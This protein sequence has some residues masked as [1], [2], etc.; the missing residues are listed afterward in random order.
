M[1]ITWLHTGDDGRSH[2][3]DI[4]VPLHQ[5]GAA[6]RSDLFAGTGA[7]FGETHRGGP[8]AFHNAP[9]RQWVVVLSGHMD[10]EIGDGTVRRFGPGEVFLADDLTGEGHLVR[11]T[12]GT[13]CIMTVPVTAELDP[14][15]WK[16]AS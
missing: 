5:E 8:G 10:V 4:L 7:A 13:R 6:L 9:R 11:P 15:G 14:P 3:Q 16:P 12:E 2:F 1:K